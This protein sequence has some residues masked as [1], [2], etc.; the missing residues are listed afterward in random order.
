MVEQCFNLRTILFKKKTRII[1]YYPNYLRYTVALVDAGYSTRED[2]SLNGIRSEA[3]WL[4]HHLHHLQ[5]FRLPDP[6]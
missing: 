3:F 1:W 4:L 5:M 6:I 2:S